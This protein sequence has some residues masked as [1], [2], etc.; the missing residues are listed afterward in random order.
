MEYRRQADQRI[1]HIESELG[2]VKADLS[3]LAAGMQ[4]VSSAVADL[5][6]LVLADKSR[7]VNVTGWIGIAMSVF[8]GAF[9]AASAISSFV[10]LS[11]K[12]L[13]SN[14]VRLMDQDARVMERLIEGAEADSESRMERD[15][16][17]TMV[18]DQ[19]DRISQL[20]DLSQ[21]LVMSSL[22][23]AD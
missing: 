19:Q 3:G 2:S 1:E 15:Y 17:R 23:K 11:I 7:P 14:Q 10:F 8:V 13:E 6:A 21:K 5:K 18:R 12:P 4:H 16:L 9:G 20:E 22:N